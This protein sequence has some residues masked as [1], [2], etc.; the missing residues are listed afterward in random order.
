MI[1]IHEK[2]FLEDY[3]FFLSGHKRDMESVSRGDV[4]FDQQ[5]VSF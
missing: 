2:H 4:I 3:F 1:C 5:K